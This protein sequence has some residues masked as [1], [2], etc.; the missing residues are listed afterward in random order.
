[1]YSHLYGESLASWHKPGK[2]L[3]N[4]ADE[5]PVTDMRFVGVLTMICFAFL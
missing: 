3:T 1:M 4:S 2:Q 5:V